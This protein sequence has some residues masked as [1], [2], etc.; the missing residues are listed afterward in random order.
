M[1]AR[2]TR[3]LGAPGSVRLHQRSVAT[4]AAAGR[5]RRGTA[6]TWRDKRLPPFRLSHGLVG[7]GQGP[8]LLGLHRL[9]AALHFPFARLGN[10][11]LSVAGIAPEPSTQK[12]WHLLQDSLLG[13]VAG[14]LCFAQAVV[15]RLRL[16]LH[17]L[18]A[19]RDCA[20]ARTSHDQLSPALGA[21]IPLSHLI[22]HMRTTF[23]NRTCQGYYS[24]A[25]AALST[26]HATGRSAAKVV[27]SLTHQGATAIITLA[28]RDR[29]PR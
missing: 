8:R 13:S 3:S 19:A 18:P 9:A 6:R 22:R 4:S 25:S 29:C 17:R 15:S 1:G 11:D 21:P 27:D 7:G 16:L 28:N 26:P 14:G 24:F 12:V 23:Q 5:G 20:I 2:L 10:E